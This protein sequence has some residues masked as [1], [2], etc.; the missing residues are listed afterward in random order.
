MHPDIFSVEDL[1]VLTSLVTSAWSTGRDR[2]WGA[3]AGTLDWTCTETA[4]HAVDTVLAPAFFLASRAQDDYP[5]F[6]WDPFTMGPEPTPEQLVHGLETAARILSAVVSTAAPDAR[7]VIWRWPEVETRPP[8]D[9]IPRGGL[10]LIL[11]AHDVCTGLRVPFEPPAGLCHR[12]REHTRPWP[13]WSLWQEFPN[14][15]DPWGDLLHASDRFR[16]P[17][18]TA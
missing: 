6:G 15:D 7:A 8:G 12:L 18:T 3:K 5:N 17:G 4:D 2:D 1:G 10:E 14:T 9:F 11:H 16:Q 13:V